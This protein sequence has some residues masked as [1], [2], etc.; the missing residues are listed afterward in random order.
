M[1]LL[2]LAGINMV[3]FELTAGRSV[4]HWDKDV[5]A[6]VSAR[7]AAALSLLLWITIIFLG[8]WIGFTTTRA[9]SKTDSDINIEE[10]FPKSP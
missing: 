10:L 1:A 5:R 8:R 9:A 3:I 2:A 4:H 6:P 7:T